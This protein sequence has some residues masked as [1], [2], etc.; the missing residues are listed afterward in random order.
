MLLPLQE[1]V[2]VGCFLYSCP[3]DS[4]FKNVYKQ[5]ECILIFIV[6]KFRESLW[7]SQISYLVLT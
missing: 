7:V 2:S 1:T 3:H 5:S 4:S 6:T